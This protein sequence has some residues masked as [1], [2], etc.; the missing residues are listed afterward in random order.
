M[1]FGSL[2]SVGM[3]GAEPSRGETKRSVGVRVGGKL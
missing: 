3:S 2:R 1:P